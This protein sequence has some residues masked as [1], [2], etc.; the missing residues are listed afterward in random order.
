MIIERYDGSL[1]L[2]LLV[3][4]L[5]ALG[6]WAFFRMGLLTKQ[7]AV[8]VYFLAVYFLGV[9]GVNWL[10]PVLAFFFTSCC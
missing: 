6:A 7:A 2:L 4:L 8:V 5:S 9:L 1:P 3:V 10:L